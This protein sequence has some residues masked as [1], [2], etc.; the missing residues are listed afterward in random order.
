MRLTTIEEE[1][2]EESRWRL[3]SAHYHSCSTSDQLSLT[4][5]STQSY[6]T[7]PITLT[8]PRPL[9]PPLPAHQHPLVQHSLHELET[10]LRTD[11][12]LSVDLQSN[13]VQFGAKERDRELETM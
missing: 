5:S 11:K 8:F 6:R 10:P 12:S 13:G 3:D 1:R 9:P 4:S 2:E 7:T